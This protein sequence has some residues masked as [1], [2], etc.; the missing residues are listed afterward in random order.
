MVDFLALYFI[1]RGMSGKG[2]YCFLLIASIFWEN[3]S[4]S[5]GFEFNEAF[6]KR[7]LIV[8]NTITLIT[9]F[10]RPTQSDT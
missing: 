9:M 5:I 2:N 1:E 4:V 10:V 6:P 8:A 7:T 3:V